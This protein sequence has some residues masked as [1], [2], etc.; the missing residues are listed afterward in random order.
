MARGR[1]IYGLNPGMWRQS[2]ASAGWGR[3]VAPVQIKKCP[4][5]LSLL[6]IS[7]IA[8]LLGSNLGHI[9]PQLYQMSPSSVGVRFLQDMRDANNEYFLRQYRQYLNDAEE[10]E[11]NWAD[12]ND[13]R[14][15]FRT[16]NLTQYNLTIDRE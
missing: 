15:Y 16:L 10:G 7:R 8:A 13:S 5:G 9:T 11:I 6:E 12:I 14:D 3:A 4:D 1:G 2:R